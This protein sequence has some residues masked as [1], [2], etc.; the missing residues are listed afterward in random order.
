MHWNVCFR[1]FPRR[2]VDSMQG[3]RDVCAESYEELQKTYVHLLTDARAPQEFTQHVLDLAFAFAP[4]PSPPS[5]PPASTSSP[6]PPPPTSPPSTPGAPSAAGALT[7]TDRACSTLSSAIERTFSHPANGFPLRSDELA[8]KPM[9]MELY[10]RF[11]EKVHFI[12]ITSIHST[13]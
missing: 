1:H 13:W 9:Q 3:M 10:L 6:A 5:A 4:P 11:W 8:G 7:Q 2:I 12:F